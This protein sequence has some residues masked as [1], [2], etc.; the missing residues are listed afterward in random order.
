MK[1]ILGKFAR[2]ELEA[3][4]GVESSVGARAAVEH[5]TRRL[6][7]PW[8]PVPPPGFSREQFMGERDEALELTVEPEI[9]EI[10]IS[11]ARKRQVTVEDVIAHAVITYLA[12]LDAASQRGRAATT[13]AS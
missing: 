10:L 4:L 6:R 12:D 5:Y 7:S 1:V 2:I 3:Q 9:E 8:A 13:P 11:E